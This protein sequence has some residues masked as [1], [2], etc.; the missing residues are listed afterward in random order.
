L[1]ENKKTK[2]QQEEYTRTPKESSKI[3]W[4]GSSMQN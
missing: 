3:G 1:E 4:G 2:Y